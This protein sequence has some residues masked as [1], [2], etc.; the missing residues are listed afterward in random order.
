MQDLLKR[1][2][3]KPLWSHSSEFHNGDLKEIDFKM[4]VK[5]KYRSALQR[6]IGEVLAIERGS[7]IHDVLMNRKGEWNCQKIPRL[8]VEETEDNL[9]E[10]TGEVEAREK[11]YRRE[12]SRKNWRT[13]TT[14]K[15]NLAEIVTEEDLGNEEVVKK[16][17]K[18]A[19]H[20]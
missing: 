4:K 20:I 19:R 16:T 15:R 17:T 8:R 9:G 10:E 1:R 12:E 7:W 3:G 5:K 14:T 11:S 2:E 6:Q 13:S 18:R